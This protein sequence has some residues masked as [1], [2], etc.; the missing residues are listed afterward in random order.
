MNIYNSILVL[1]NSNYFIQVTIERAFSSLKLILADNRNRLN[2]NTLEN[3][4]IVKLN[5]DYLDT[6]VETLQLFEEEV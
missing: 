5:A 3:I 1:T 4:L 6:A 2:H